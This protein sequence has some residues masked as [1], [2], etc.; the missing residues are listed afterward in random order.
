[1]VHGAGS[2]REEN[3]FHSALRSVHETE[4]YV[5]VVSDDHARFFR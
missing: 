1:V 4:L 3:A 5:Q 2:W